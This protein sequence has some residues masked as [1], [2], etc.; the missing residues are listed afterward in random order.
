MTLKCS[1][2]NISSALEEVFDK[3]L[4]NQFAKCIAYGL[5]EE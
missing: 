2:V 5:M 1:Y 4:C 3:S